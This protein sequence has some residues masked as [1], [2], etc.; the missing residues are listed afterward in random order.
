V[1]WDRTRK[2]Q[3]HCRAG[4]KLLF[5][6]TKGG[7]YQRGGGEWEGAKN[8]PRALKVNQTL[9]IIDLNGSNI[10]NEVAEVLAGAL[11]VN[12]SLQEICLTTNKIGNDGVQS[13][14]DALKV[15]Q[16]LKTIDSVCLKNYSDVRP[17][18]H[19]SVCMSMCPYGVPQY[20]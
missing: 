9:Q 17:S 14:A 7:W 1:Q 10:G 12:T 15:N 20:V 11:M 13:Q 8:L 19:L 2:W 18:I 4:I 6:N 16:T 5:L 3:I